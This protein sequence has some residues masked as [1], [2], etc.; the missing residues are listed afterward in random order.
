MPVSAEG[1]VEH[2]NEPKRPTLCGYLVRFGVQLGSLEKLIRSGAPGRATLPY[3]REI[4]N[5]RTQHHWC[6]VKF[7]ELKKKK[8]SFSVIRKQSQV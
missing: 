4:I 3:M 1:R 6:T 5:L 2:Q 8:H 7:V